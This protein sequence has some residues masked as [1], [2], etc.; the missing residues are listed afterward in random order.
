MKPSAEL[1]DPARFA[2]AIAR[3]AERRA[4]SPSFTRLQEGGVSMT[5]LDRNRDR[6]A[7]LLVADLLAGHV[8]E[9]PGRMY[10]IT[11]QGKERRLF[12]FSPVEMIVQDAVANWLAEQSSGAF[13]TRL[14][15]Y[16]TGISYR[17]ALRDFGRY[18][19]HSRRSGARGLYVLR[20]DVRSY[21]DSIPVRDD[22]PLWA[23]LEPF[24]LGSSRV[25]PTRALLRRALRPQLVDACGE[26][27]R[28][29]CGIP[30]GSPVANVVA[31]L[32][33]RAMDVELGQVA[34]AFYAR[35]G[36][37]I[38]VAHPD[39][40]TIEALARSLAGYLSNYEV[41]GNPAKVEDCYLTTA[42]RPDPAGHV[43]RGVSA[44]EFL[45]HRVTA[46]GTV[47]MSRG[48]T[49]ALLQALRTGAANAAR[50]NAPS[51]DARIQRIVHSVNALLSPRSA[52]AHPYAILLRATVTDR[53]Y[54][55]W[56][57]HEVALIVLEAA[58]GRRRVTHFRAVPP[59]RLRTAFRLRSLVAARNG[60]RP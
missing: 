42:G 13:S 48:K 32:Y 52:A 56:L 8:A 20:R 24:V 14:Y 17:H 19:R 2:N 6:V 25:E 59:G 31:N 28:L 60:D 43:F 26:P 10:S 1:F 46:L 41:E 39:T 4:S 50:V 22:A 16:R 21:F 18:V 12:E 5:T 36:D 45:G 55:A 9:R 37:D 57:D 29:E 3:I 58:F 11:Q 34:A 23:S 54:L 30:T 53:P 15:S 27:Y 47:G 7:R 33:L 40:A 44:V 38:I 49:R 35:Y 51:I